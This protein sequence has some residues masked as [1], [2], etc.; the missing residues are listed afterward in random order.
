MPDTSTRPSPVR[1]HLLAVA[2]ELFY[3]EGITGVGVERI[4]AEADTTRATLYRHFRGKEDLVVAYIEREDALLR[5][6]FAGAE[7]AAVSPEH[8]LVM[9]VE[10]IADDATRHHTRGCPFINATAEYPDPT[11]GV[12]R[13]VADH[14]QWFR[15]SLRRFFA[16]ADRSEAA[17]DQLVMLRDAVLVGCY[18]DDAEVVRQTFLSAARSV[19]ELD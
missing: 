8:L 7:A 3:R 1:E 17:A 2:S 18:L 4:L 16:A 19:A 12:R 9:A 14:R 13:A 15:D 6:I 10:G 5:E 11:S